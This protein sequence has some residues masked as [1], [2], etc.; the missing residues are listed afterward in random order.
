MMK[1]T[2]NSILRAIFA[3][4][5]GLVM[6]LWSDKALDY[7]IL[8][9]GVLFLIPGLITLARFLVLKAKENTSSFPI[10]GLGSVLIG[11]FLIISPAFFTNILTIILGLILALGGLQQIVVLYRSQ[12][13]ISVP[14][15]FFLV[16]VLILAVG[17]LVVFNPMGFKRT[18]LTIVGVAS[19]VYALAELINW[20]KF[21]RHQPIADTN[22]L[23]VESFTDKNVDEN[24]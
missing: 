17:L 21:G 3:F 2:S 9:I 10:E 1:G 18:L 5:L 12:R 6:I 8:T 7:L 23:E 24:H 13:W 22:N 15:V 14:F 16:P 19:V 4:A 20:A 11:L